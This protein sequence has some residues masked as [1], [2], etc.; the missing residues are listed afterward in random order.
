MLTLGLALMLLVGIYFYVMFGPLRN[1]CWYFDRV[2]IYML[3]GDQGAPRVFARTDMR[4][5]VPPFWRGRG[6]QVRFRQLTF[7]VGLLTMRVGTLEDQFGLRVYDI[8]EKQ[9]RSWRR[10]NATRPA[11]QQD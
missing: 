5:K 6:V 1:R 10:G 11:P 9:L 7:Q 4:L 3:A 2:P 8:E